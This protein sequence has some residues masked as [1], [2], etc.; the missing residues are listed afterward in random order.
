MTQILIS[1]LFPLPFS[2]NFLHVYLVSVAAINPHMQEAPTHTLAGPLLPVLWLHCVK[3]K[4]HRTALGLPRLHGPL[5]ALCLFSLMAYNWPTSLESSQMTSRL[6]RPLGT[7]I[8]RERVQAAGQSGLLPGCSFSPSEQA[9][10]DGTGLEMHIPNIT[11]LSRAQRHARIHADICTHV[12]TS[13]G[14]M[15]RY[16][17][18]PTHT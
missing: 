7:R 12:H 3:A 10:Q 6:G 4:A 17:H 5:H 14:N 2:P 15:L 9:T 18:A 1:R 11:N 16:I 8:K 13:A